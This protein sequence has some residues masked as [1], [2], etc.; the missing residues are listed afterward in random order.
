[1]ARAR[2]LLA[3]M[4]APAIIWNA[5]RVSLVVG[6]CL[7]VINQGPAVW[8]GGSVDWIKLALNHAVPFLVASYSGAKMALAQGC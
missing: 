8:H 6:V 4:I 7:N 2:A 5:V 1:M 3:A